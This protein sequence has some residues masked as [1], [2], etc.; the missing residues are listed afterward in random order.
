MRFNA[1]E[2]T[3]L[4]IIIVTYYQLKS[5]NQQTFMNNYTPFVLFLFSDLQWR[6]WSP[7]DLSLILMSAMQSSP[8]PAAAFSLAFKYFDPNSPLLKFLLFHEEFVL[9][10]N[11]D[12]CRKCLNEF[13]LAIDK[14]CEGCQPL[15]LHTHT[16][17]HTYVFCTCRL[18]TLATSL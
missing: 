1:G 13:T 9:R 10:R 12:D 6:H 8:S 4:C 14:V 17:C 16:Q 7:F 15:L 11:F 5:I 2:N 3:S 18:S